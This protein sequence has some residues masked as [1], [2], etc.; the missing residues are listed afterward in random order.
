ML[1]N[2]LISLR[3]L[4]LPL[5][6]CHFLL[7]TD[8]RSEFENRMILQSNS[9]GFYVEKSRQVTWTLKKQPSYGM[10]HIL[11]SVCLTN[12]MRSVHDATYINEEINA[13]LDEAWTIVPTIQHS[14]HAIIRNKWGINFF[15]E[16]WRIIKTKCVLERNQI[17]F[18]FRVVRGLWN[19]IIFWQ[20]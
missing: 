9:V 15:F 7:I 11:V 4:D 8:H 5:E 10:G 12:V 20:I 14:A 2:S 16:W 1:Y 17:A 13:R 6:F 18:S 3:T 19:G